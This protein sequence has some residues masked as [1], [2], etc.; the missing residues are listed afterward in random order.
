MGGVGPFGL[1]L[2][3]LL[4][5]VVLLVVLVVIPWGRRQQRNEIIDPRREAAISRMRA[6]AWPLPE[7]YRFDRDEANER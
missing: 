4:V 3:A 5:V 1:V 6:R 2:I 7:N